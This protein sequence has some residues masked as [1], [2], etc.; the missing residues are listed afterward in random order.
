MKIYVQKLFPNGF[1]KTRFF[2]LSWLSFVLAFFSVASVFGTAMSGTYTV[3]NSA[4]NYSTIN[5][6]LSAVK[7]NGISGP[8]IINIASGTWNETISISSGAISGLSNKNTLTFRGAGF[9]TIINASG[10]VVSLTSV[11]YVIF[12]NLTINMTGG[13][14]GVYLSSTSY[15]NFVKCQIKSTAS[16]GS[17]NSAAY[18]SNGTYNIFDSCRF[19]GADYDI[20]LNSGSNN[21]VTNSRILNFNYDGIY[22][23][24]TTSNFYIS[25]TIDSALNQN[26]DGVYSS[27]ESGARYF[28]NNVAATDAGCGMFLFYCNSSSTTDS[29]N[30]VNNIVGPAY[31]GNGIV[32]ESGVSD[33]NLHILHNTIHNNGV[34]ALGSNYPAFYLVNFTTT[35]VDIRNNEISWDGSGYCFALNT[36]A[37]VLTKGSTVYESGNNIYNTGGTNLIYVNGSTYNSLA[38]YEAAN[39]GFGANDMTIPPPFVSA[40]NLR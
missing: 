12:H 14:Y 10:P 27:Y 20:Y 11:S 24:N 9:G 1:S 36:A 7:T 16:T 2:K 31:A 22:G 30:V 34:N 21:F 38:S 15:D 29:F 6:A 28:N 4:C 25:N 26:T 5:G 40:S 18:I 3:C 37:G 39:A 32:I 33:G 13:T 23:S 19:N 8:V 17:G 35:G